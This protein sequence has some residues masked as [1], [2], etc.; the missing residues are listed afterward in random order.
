MLAHFGD[1]VAFLLAKL[2]HCVVYS[3]YKEH[4]G[5]VWHGKVVQ[6]MHKVRLKP[7]RH[8]RMVLVGSRCNSYTSQ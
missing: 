3:K 7:A 8:L 6:K 2:L 5:S 4:P 1:H